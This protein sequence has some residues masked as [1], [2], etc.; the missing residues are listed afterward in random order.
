[1]AREDNKCVVIVTHDEGILE[2][3]DRSFHMM[4]GKLTP[5]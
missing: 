3:A 5:Y 4:D 1:L 2:V